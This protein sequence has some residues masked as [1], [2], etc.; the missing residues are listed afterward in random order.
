MSTHEKKSG[1]PKSTL[2]LPSG[3]AVHAQ[4]RGFTGKHQVSHDAQLE[5]IASDPYKVADLTLTYQ[6]AE[7]LER[8]YP[9]HPWQ[10][11]VSHAQGVAMIKLPILMSATQQYVLHISSLKSDPGLKSV[12][13]AG[14][15][16]L[17]RH[18][19]PRAGFTLTP[20]LEARDKA[21]NKGKKLLVV[22]P[23]TVISKLPPE[24]R[25]RLQLPELVTSGPR[26]TVRLPTA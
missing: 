4:R 8:H 26:E 10:V 20:F 17:E 15:E 7:T 3:H 6:I 13:R 11:A 18:N 19:I 24:D 12:V 25:Y 21:R 2:P 9:A 14:G 23:A 1:A 22:D 16:L 5:D